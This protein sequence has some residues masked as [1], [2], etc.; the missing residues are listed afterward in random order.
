MSLYQYS[1]TPATNAT[2]ADDI[3]WSTGVVPSQVDDN[4]KQQMAD[5]ADWLLDL[6]CSITT[7]GTSSAAT[8]STNGGIDSLRDGLIVGLVAH[9]DMDAAATLNIDGLGAKP[10]YVGGS[11]IADGQ[12][13][14][15]AHY[16]V[17]YDA[18]VASGAW[19]VH[20]AAAVISDGSVTTDKLA[21]LAVT[22]A[23]L[24]VDAVTTARIQNDAVTTAKIADGAVDTNQ[25]ASFA[26]TNA[27][28]AVDAVSTARIQN[29]AVTGAKI[30]DGAVGGDQLAAGGVT[31]TKLANMAQYRVKGRIASGNGA[32]TDLT[33]DNLGTILG[34]VSA[35]I[36]LPVNVVSSTYDAGTTSG[37]GYQLSSEGVLRVQ[38]PSSAD[39]TDALF[40]G[41][42]GT[43]LK[44]QI[45]A[46]G[47]FESATNSY[48]ATSD[49]RIKRDIRN[50]KPCLEALMQLPLHRGR[51]KDEVRENPR[52]APDREFVIADEMVDVGLGD[53]VKTGDGPAFLQR[54]N[55][56]GLAFKTLKGLQEAVTEYRAEIAA[57]K[58]RIAAL[59][60]A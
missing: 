37:A 16:F 5:I 28:L 23:K 55:Y 20:N 12:L 13:G 34:Q 9:T 24:A 41:F 36:T 44:A 46:N 57:L 26:V 51:L 11:A 38:R 7:G 48:G 30:A 59:E 31:S 25:L 4:N 19:I 39:N 53:L 14:S 27:K 40:N 32:P 1:T 10:L 3:N 22:N 58:T 54:V 29:E 8:A 21:A 50:M 35:A 15:G 33:P 47:D 17:T 43:L 56:S 2:A 42:K 45:E 52:G 60:E 6:A 18:S 49:R